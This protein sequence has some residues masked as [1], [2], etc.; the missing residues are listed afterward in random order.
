MDRWSDFGLLGKAAFISFAGG[1]I[2]MGIAAIVGTATG[3]G[4]LTMLALAIWFA[5]AIV[6]AICAFASAARNAWP[7]TA[8][9]LTAF[10]VLGAI[11]S[12]E[13]WE[14]LPFVLI[15]CPVFTAIMA[16]IGKP[17][18]ALLSIGRS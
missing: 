9:C 11:F 4:D 15:G 17:A 3:S 10:M 14:T 13:H 7:T 12:P 2:G 1:M 6:W 8:G 16:I 5:P 18:E